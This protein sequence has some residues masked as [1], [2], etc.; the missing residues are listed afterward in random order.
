M[1]RTCTDCSLSSH[2]LLLAIILH[3]YYAPIP[4]TLFI[5]TDKPLVL[6]E[7]A[8][9]SQSS[10]KVVVKTQEISPE[11]NVAQND[12][13]GRLS[14][15]QSIGQ[16]VLGSLTPDKAQSSPVQTATDK[17]LYMHAFF[18]VLS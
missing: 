13:S 17:G 16:D 6:L 12:N 11:S 18:Q 4:T 3:V 10:T 7:D 1:D 2:I 14:Q 9:E 5:S 15:P 8:H